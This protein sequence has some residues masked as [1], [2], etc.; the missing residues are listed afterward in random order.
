MN[1][2]LLLIISISFSVAL[3]ILIFIQVYWINYDFGVKQDLFEQRVTEA[4]NITASKLEKLDTK[5]SYKKIK[6]RTQGITFNMPNINGKISDQIN[7]KLFNESSID[8]N[9]YSRSQFTTKD[10]VA[11]SL[12]LDPAAASFLKDLKEKSGLQ[13][14]NNDLFNLLK[15]YSFFD[16]T[17]TRNYYTD[18]KQKVDTLLLDSILS[19]ELTKQNIRAKHIYYLTLLHPGS[20]HHVAAVVEHA[21]GIRF[22]DKERFDVEEYC[23]SEGWVKVPAGRTVDRKGKPLL[24]KLKGKVEPFYR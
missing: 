3:L 17:S 21:I 8:S 18:F 6:T 5:G 19:L 11:D 1:K 9:G 20:A 22:N 16:E 15:G 2:R 13:Q 23:I 7:F 4:L 14:S 24:I 10:I 12:K